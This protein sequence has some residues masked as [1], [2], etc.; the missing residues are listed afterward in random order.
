MRTADIS[1]KPKEK[2]RKKEEKNKEKKKTE[3]KAGKKITT[4]KTT[5]MTLITTTTIK[6]TNRPLT[7]ELRRIGIPIDNYLLAKRKKELTKD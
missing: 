3:T 7:I 6:T 2:R 5:S 4:I 1:P